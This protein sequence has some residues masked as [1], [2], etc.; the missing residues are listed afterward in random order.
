MN[1]GK[2]TRVV[3]ESYRHRMDESLQHRRYVMDYTSWLS[4]NILIYVYVHMYPAA[5]A[6]SHRFRNMLRTFLFV[7][8]P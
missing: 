2:L 7:N 8:L 4:Y 3:H 1:H 6:I 5:S